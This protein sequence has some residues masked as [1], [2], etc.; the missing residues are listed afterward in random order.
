[1]QA[2]APATG[3][4]D[5]AIVADDSVARPRAAH[6]GPERRRPQILDVAFGLFVRDGYRATSMEEIARAAGVSKPVVYACFPSKAELFGALLEREERRMLEQ[7]GAALAVADRR[8]DPETILV[9]G[10]TAMLRAVTETPEAYRIAL[11]GGADAVVDMRV[12]RGR[13]REVAALTAAARA[14]LEGKTAPEGVDAAAQFVG[15]TLLGIGE[16]GVRMLLAAPEHW[17]PET[18][19]RALGRL[20]A[21]GFAAL[22]GDGERGADDRN[23]DVAPRRGATSGG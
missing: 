15:Q 10:F 17:T 8:G 1:M 5:A 12:R 23:D 11:L 20:A 14:W 21:G 7:F 2:R 4:S 19:G 16:A 13:E 9:A 18:L 3:Q 6:L 22:T